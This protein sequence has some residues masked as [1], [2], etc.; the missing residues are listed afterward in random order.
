MHPQFFK[1]LAIDPNVP[2]ESLHPT[3]PHNEHID[4]KRA[5]LIYQ[6]RKRGILET[7]LLLSTFAKIFEIIL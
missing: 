6:S 5:R 2:Y 4:K 1:Y 3:T 7:D